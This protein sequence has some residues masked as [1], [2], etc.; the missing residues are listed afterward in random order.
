MQTSGIKIEAQE[1]PDQL[2]GVSRIPKKT[3][4]CETTSVTAHGNVFCTGQ[5][6]HSRK[7][8]LELLEGAFLHKPASL[9]WFL[10]P[11]ECR[12]KLTQT[13]TQQRLQPTKAS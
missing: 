13:N 9:Q 2:L 10:A 12:V 11:P 1:T 7:R 4:H 3:A 8:L 5:P 6:W